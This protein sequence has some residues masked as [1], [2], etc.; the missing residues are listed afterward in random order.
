M[1]TS[2]DL[3]LVC[4]QMYIFL[5]SQCYSIQLERNILRNLRATDPSR[6][7]IRLSFVG[8]GGNSN[9]ANATVWFCGKR[10]GTIG[11]GIVNE[12]FLTNCSRPKPD[13]NSFHTTAS[14]T[15]QNHCSNSSANPYAIY[16]LP[17]AKRNRCSN[18][19]VDPDTQMPVQTLHIMPP[20]PHPKTAAATRMAVQTRFTYSNAS[21]KHFTP[22]RRR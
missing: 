9:K 16:P 2:V 8:Y 1:V 21:T 12:R 14:C 15:R 20:V 7:M 13:P 18:A 10:E 6:F 19:N 3:R 4:L 17:G 22:R 11:K 5:D